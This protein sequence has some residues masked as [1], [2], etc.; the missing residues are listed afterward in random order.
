MI[1]TPMEFYDA[2]TKVAKPHEDQ[3]ASWTC[4]LHC[5]VTPQTTAL[6]ED[7]AFAHLITKFRSVIDGEM[8]YEVPW[9]YKPWWEENVKG[10]DKVEE[11]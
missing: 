1:Q 11:F 7:C 8:W 4:D 10:G 5:K 3:I 6:V 2:L 9:A